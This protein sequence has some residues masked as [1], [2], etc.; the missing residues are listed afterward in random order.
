[1]KKFNILFVCKYN[2]FRSRISEA[3]LRKIN[4]N[5]RIKADSAGIFKGNPIS[6]KIISIGK[7]LGLKIKGAPK[8]INIKL[9]KWQ[10]IIVIVAD[11]IPKK[12]F[13]F[14]KKRG[15]KTIVWKIKDDIK[16]IPIIIRKVDE[17][18]KNLQKLKWNQ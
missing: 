14:N 13:S 16:S 11:N 9:L 17:L 15:K 10:N 12:L 3:Y 1:M 6:K 8:S 7:K 2:R 5:K 4:K 18:N